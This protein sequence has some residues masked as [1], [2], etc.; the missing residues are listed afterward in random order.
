ME[1]STIPIAPGLTLDDHIVPIIIG[2]DGSDGFRPVS[3][4]GTGF[5]VA[6]GVLVTCW[7]CVSAVPPP[8]ERYAAVLPRPG[9][10]GYKAAFIGNVSQHPS[11]I[12]LALAS[13]DH[14]PTTLL[15]I[16]AMAMRMGAD[17]TSFG[18]PYSNFVRRTDSTLTLMLEGRY[19]Q[20]YVTRAFRD[21][22]RGFGST[23]AY[24]L[25]MPTPEGLSGAPLLR[26]GT[27][28]VIG[29]VYGTSEVALIK[30]FETI[31][32]YG[33][34]EPE[35]QRIVTFGLA[36]YTTALHTLSGPATNGVPLLEY[37]R[38]QL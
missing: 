12:D 17:V 1:T 30:H 21:Q 20:G 18:Y 4:E 29:V 10:S 23:E 9:E 6:P 32:N 27:A 15:S 5:V 2:R 11:G 25:D 31:D 37:V 16:S 34:R 8:E 26:M 24:E 3:F 19:L 22:D 33:R 28:E 38:K 36:H 35:V 13:I 7:H 14:R